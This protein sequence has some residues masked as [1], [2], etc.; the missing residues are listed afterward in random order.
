MIKDALQTPGGSFMPLKASQIQIHENLE[1]LQTFPFHS[2]PDQ[3]GG[4]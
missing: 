1:H 2:I 4:R 3:L